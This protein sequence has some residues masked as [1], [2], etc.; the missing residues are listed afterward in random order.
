ME[1]NQKITIRP[2]DLQVGDV[3]EEPES[4]EE[5]H[6]Q[7]KAIREQYE[8]LELQ[9]RGRGPGLMTI[10]LTIRRSDNNITEVHMVP[11]VWLTVKRLSP[12]E[13]AAYDP[14]RRIAEAQADRRR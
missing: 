9:Y 1:T 4:E 3:F 11:W 8:V 7:R 6:G 10:A 12:S 13:A 14:R 5:F 2:K